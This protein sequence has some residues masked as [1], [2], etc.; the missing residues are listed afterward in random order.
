MTFVLL[1][2]PVNERLHAQLRWHAIIATYYAII[3][4][5]DLASERWFAIATLCKVNNGVQQGAPS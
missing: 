2:K 3:D 4:R 1:P 5:A